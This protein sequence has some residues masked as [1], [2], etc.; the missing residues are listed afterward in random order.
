[1]EAYWYIACRSNELRRG[2]LATTI[3]E[4][5]L[6]LF[7]GPEGRAAALED[8]CL[9]RGAALSMG[10]IGGGVLACPYHGWRYATD[11]RVVEIPS[12]PERCPVPRHLRAP[13][14]PL[15]EQD[16]FVWVCP[17]P[18]PAV[19]RPRRFPLLG[20]AGWTSFRMKTVFRA[21]VEDCLE[22]F[23]DCPHATTVHRSWFRSP[24]SKPVRVVIRSLEDGAVAEY[25]EEPREKS[26][27]WAL[28][29]PGMPG[30]PLKVA[31]P[32]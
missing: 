19:E 16:G 32:A 20:E 25:F 15:A 18:S 11:G 8:R 6:V 23:L 21:P 29:S 27:V 10:A 26:V 2:P 4:R 5:P 12:M 7:R 3:L 24:A 9:H 28:L 31:A 14:Y 22:N 17:A 1:M 30:P 13:S